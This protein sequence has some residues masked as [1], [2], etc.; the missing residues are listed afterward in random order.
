M[1][2]EQDTGKLGILLGIL[3]MAPHDMAPSCGGG[4]GG[5]GRGSSGGSGGGSPMS[6]DHS[7][8]E[9][10]DPQP[11]KAAV[12]E[13]AVVR[14][15]AAA[16]DKAGE[17]TMTAGER[18]RSRA[19]KLRQTRSRNAVRIQ[20]QVY[21]S[22]EDSE[23]EEEEEEDVKPDLAMLQA[24]ALLAPGVDKQ[25]WKKQ[26]RMIRN[27]ESAALSRKRKRD[28][29]ESL[30]EQVAKLAEENRGLRHRLAKYEASPQQARYKYA[31]QT[32][33]TPR[34]GAPR[35]TPSGGSRNGSSGNNEGPAAGPAAGRSRVSGGAAAAAFGGRD[36]NSGG[37]G[38]GSRFT[39]GG[40]NCG[41]PVSCLNSRDL[42]AVETAA[43]G[44]TAATSTTT[45]A[46]G[47]NDAGLRRSL[48]STAGRRN[49]SSSSPRPAPTS[50]TTSTPIAT[51]AA[52]TSGAVPAIN[53]GQPL[54]SSSANQLK[55]TKKNH[56]LAVAFP[57][58]NGAPA[59]AA[60]ASAS[61]P[62]ASPSPAGSELPLKQ[63]PNV[64]KMEVTSDCDEGRDEVVVPT[65][66]AAVVGD[67]GYSSSSTLGDSTHFAAGGPHQQQAVEFDRDD[68]AACDS[69]L[70]DILS[71]GDG[72]QG[73]GNED[74]GFL[75]LLSD[76]DMMIVNPASEGL[77]VGFVKRENSS[78]SNC[79]M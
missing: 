48:R 1:R 3:D 38:G 21:T 50:A 25:A 27:R 61:S 9:V 20:Q 14:P 40:V 59:A 8:R 64:V 76:D 4:G 73:D 23:D 32:A 78:I 46:T 71:G 57:T 77:N 69:L 30:E 65:P 35:A 68:D 2:L 13:P 55:P 17:T 5:G 63:L 22:A 58:S 6:L 34:S 56:F 16:D 29:I 72:Q 15:A 45:N 47:N 18:R 24:E 79:V 49:A 39:G 26:Q 67:S 36:R 53:P 42:P 66:S 70:M 62:A 75:S 60:P 33:T 41:K 12:E 74:D 51:I 10:P 19:L 28:K 31:R 54:A 44:P 7:L 43:H 11:T 52:A 37:G